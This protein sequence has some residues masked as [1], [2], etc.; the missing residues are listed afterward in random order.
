MTA[1]QA[2]RTSISRFETDLCDETGR[3]LTA[4]GWQVEELH[5]YADDIVELIRSGKFDSYSASSLAASLW[6]E[7]R[8]CPEDF[9]S[10]IDEVGGWLTAWKKTK[11]GRAI[12]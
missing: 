11:V 8:K 3:I 9:Y 6:R 7:A 2:G 4:G 10:L 5:E 12:R 1:P